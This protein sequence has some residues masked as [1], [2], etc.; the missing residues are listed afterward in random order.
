M[1]YT[2]TIKW[3]LDRFY[4]FQK[5]EKNYYQ[6]G[7]ERINYFCSYLGHPQNAF[8][9]IH[10]AGTNGKGSTAHM[11]YSILQEEKYNIGLFTSPHLIN[12][13]ER[14]F[15]NGKLIDKNFIIE[16]I[17]QNKKIIEQKNISFFELNTC[18][19]FEYFKNQKVFMAII[20]TGLGGRLDSTNIIIP[21]ISVIT[22]VS[23]DHT[24]ILGN[25]L[26]QIALEKAGIIKNNISVIIGF[27]KNYIKHIFLQEALKKNAPIYFVKK[28]KDISM[29]SIPCESIYQNYN[30]QLVLKIVELL[31]NKKNII[32]SNQSIKN[33]FIK[34]NKNTNFQG[35]WQILQLNPKI[36]CDIAHNE[37][38]IKIINQQLK[39]EFYNKLHLVLGFVKDKNVKKI[40]QYFP[41]DAFYYFCQPNI[42]RKLSIQNLQDLVKIKNNQYVQFFYSVKDAFINAKYKSNKEDL[43]LISGSTFTVSEILLNFFMSK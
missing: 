26:S 39:K 2:E 42:D 32:I 5:K 1:N 20:E 43:I 24:K 22:N 34:I 30:K 19:A 21:E 6:T 36:I 7:L 35:R 13:R 31:I 23:K 10:I 11:L 37:E 40:L 9:S 33:G 3:I 14:I 27:C 41:S 18:L 8:K 16:F 38:G 28:Q 4:S 12:F 25:S 17:N 29:Y 15:C